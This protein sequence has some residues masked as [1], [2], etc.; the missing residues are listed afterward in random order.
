[1]LHICVCPGVQVV[2]DVACGVT[3][4]KYAIFRCKDVSGNEDLYIF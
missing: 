4:H 3:L 1:M 2:L